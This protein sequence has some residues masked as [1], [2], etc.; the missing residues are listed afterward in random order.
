MAHVGVAR[1]GEEPSAKVRIGPKLGALLGEPQEGVLQEVV[2]EIAISR[3]A[4]QEPPNA[5]G[6]GGVCQVEAPGLA[7]AEQGD[8]LAV[9]RVAHTEG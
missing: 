7:T 2:R 8:Y 1:N 4:Q 3:Q 5:P 9:L 6:V